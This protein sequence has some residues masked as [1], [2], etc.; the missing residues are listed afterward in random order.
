VKRGRTTKV[1]LESLPENILVAPFDTGAARAAH[2]GDRD[3][4]FRDRDR[5]SLLRRVADQAIVTKIVALIEQ[6]SG[7][8]SPQEDSSKGA[9]KP[10]SKTLTNPEGQVDMERRD[11]QFVQD[12]ILAG[13]RDLAEGRVFESSGGFKADM[14]PLDRKEA[15]GWK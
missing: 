8:R 15:D 5:R 2:F 9:Q 12:A 13:Y 4:S 6:S 1:L 3:R 7:R 14:A 11:G 10:R